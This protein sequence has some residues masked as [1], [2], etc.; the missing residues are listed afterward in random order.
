MIDLPSYP[1]LS[2]YFCSITALCPV[3]PQVQVD[4]R[5]GHRQ[6]VNKAVAAISGGSNLSNKTVLDAGCGTGSLAIPLAQRNA[7]NIV[8]TDI[9]EAMVAET[10]KA[11]AGQ[12]VNEVVK[13]RVGDVEE[14]FTQSDNDGQLFDIVCC[15]DVMIHYPSQRVDAM[16]EALTR[17]C[18]NTLVVSFA[19]ETLAYWVLKRV[20]EL[21]PGPSKATRAYLHREEDVERAINRHGFRIVS[22]DMT[23][24]DFYF[25]RMLICE[26]ATDGSS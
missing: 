24:T 25:S 14:D 15:L 26:R 19:P 22:R 11:A 13:A 2:I 3:L 7:S 12:G 17:Q 5:E 4:I 1:F 16:V 10:Q 9:S 6:T 23:A 18:A 8:A 20:G 21:A